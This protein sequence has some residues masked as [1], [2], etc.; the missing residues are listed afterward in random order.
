MVKLLLILVRLALEGVLDF[1]VGRVD[2]QLLQAV[3]LEVL[4]ARDVQEPDLDRFVAFAEM[5]RSL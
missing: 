4:V 3:L 1:L 5:E 2:E